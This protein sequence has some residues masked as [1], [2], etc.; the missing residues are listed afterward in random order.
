M[1]TDTAA[2]TGETSARSADLE[3]QIIIAIVIGTHKYL[4]RGYGV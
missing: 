3:Q 1:T 2:P 4:Y